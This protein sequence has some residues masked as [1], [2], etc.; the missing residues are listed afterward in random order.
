[1]VA[2]VLVR[3]NIIT[4]YIHIVVVVLKDAYIVMMEINVQNVILNII[5]MK[6]K[7]VI[8]VKKIVIIVM[9][10]K[11]AMNVLMDII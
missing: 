6:I 3:I 7:N 11:N 8:H 1:M 9:M 2:N 10:E 5:N 4:N